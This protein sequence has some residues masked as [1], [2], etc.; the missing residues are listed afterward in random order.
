[1]FSSDLDLFVFD[2]DPSS[3]VSASV[4][5]TSFLPTLI[6]EREQVPVPDIMMNECEV[7]TSLTVNAPL[8]IVR[9]VTEASSSGMLLPYGRC[10]TGTGSEFN[11]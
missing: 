7:S 2:L 9:P 5:V 6:L 8:P 10:V 11:E 3:P 1:M 4:S